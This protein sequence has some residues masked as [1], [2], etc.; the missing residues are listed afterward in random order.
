M[1]FPN[2]QLRED[3]LAV[4]TIFEDLTPIF[5]T[6]VDI[7]TFTR[8]IGPYYN[9][10]REYDLRQ[11]CS[12]T[13]RTFD[14]VS[15]E[16]LAFSKNDPAV[17]RVLASIKARPIDNLETGIN[18]HDALIRGWDLAGKVAQTY[19]GSR[20][21]IVDN[22]RHNISTG[23][24]CLQ[25]IAARLVQ[26]YLFFL[27]RALEQKDYAENRPGQILQTVNIKL[28]TGNEPPPVVEHASSSS[29]SSSYMPSHHEISE[30]DLIREAI[31]Q[32]L[33]YTPLA[34]SASS[35]ELSFEEQMALAQ[36]LSLEQAQE[37]E[38]D[39]EE[40]MIARAMGLI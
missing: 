16:I 24:G 25:G 31:E 30:E 34:S 2:E 13:E 32:S 9:R 27:A 10:A 15:A 8:T 12:S 20:E 19:K 23:G 28:H 26:P 5:A 14:Q 17:A 1:A 22:L 39:D 11:H 7:H 4:R 37:S 6:A 33:S 3:Y 38:E 29:S 18:L 35:S 40:L 36:Q 21:I